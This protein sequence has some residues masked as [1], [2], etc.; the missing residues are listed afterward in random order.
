MQVVRCLK[1]FSVFHINRV[2]NNKTTTNNNNNRPTMQLWPLHAVH[3]IK[4]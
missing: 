2:P 3:N 4:A 1:V